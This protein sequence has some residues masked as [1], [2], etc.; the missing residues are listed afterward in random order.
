MRDAGLI[1]EELADEHDGVPASGAAGQRPAGAGRFARQLD[2]LFQT[3]HATL[4]PRPVPRLEKAYTVPDS[5]RSDVQAGILHPFPRIDAGLVI[6]LAFDSRGAAASF[7]EALEQPQWAV[8]RDADLSLDP[9]A[10]E[11]GAADQ[12]YRHL[13]FTAAGLRA[14]GLDD[15]ELELF[16]EEFR[17][18]MAQRAGLLGDVNANHPRRWHLPEAFDNAGALGVELDGVH[19][20]LQL[21]CLVAA[22]LPADADAVP[23]VLQAE[24][25]HIRQLPV[26]PRILSVQSLRRYYRREE[27]TRGS[28]ELITEHYGYADG[29]GQ[30]EIEWGTQLGEFKRNRVALGEVLLGHPNAQDRPLDA[31]CP[32][33]LQMQQ[34][35]LQWQHNGSY[36]VMRKYR[37]RVQMFNAAIEVTA[38]AMALALD[39]DTGP[40][41]ARLAHYGAIVRAKLM[42]RYPDGRSV[43]D[44]ANPRSVNAFTYDLDPTGSECPFHAHARR[45]HP[46]AR[47][48]AVVRAPRLMRRSMS[49]GPPAA[50]GET[51]DSEPPRGL[52]FMAYNTSIGE[53]FEVVQR[54]LAGGN[55]TGSSS[56]IA[57]PIVGTPVTGLP[58]HFRFE[59]EK[60]AFVVELDPCPPG[61]N[62]FDEQQVMTRLEWGLYLYSPSMTVLHRLRQRAAAVGSTPPWQIERGRAQ[63]RRLQ[64]V[65]AAGNPG[66]ALDAWKA[67][68]EDPESIDRMDSAALWAAIRADHGGLLRTPYGVLVAER[69]LVADV[70]LDRHQRYSV[71]GQ[72][73]RMRRSFGEIALGM[74]ESPEYRD[75]STAI[76]DEIGRLNK[77]AVFDSARAAVDRKIEEIRRLAFDQSQK[78]GD[79]RLEAGLDARELLDEVLA[80]LSEDWFGLQDSRGD[81]LFRRGPTDWQWQS[82]QLPLYPGHFTALSRY[83]FQPHPGP[84][85]TELGQRYGQSLRTAMRTL[86]ERHRKAG[87]TPMVPN[88]GGAATIEPAP[89]AKAVIEDPKH[90]RDATEASD[91]MARTLVGVLMGF[92]PTIIGA[93]LNVLAEWFREGLFGTMRLK[94]AHATDMATAEAVLGDAITTALKMRPM[95]QI[96]WRTA[97]ADHRLGNEPLHAVQ[98]Q[99]GDR[100]VMSIASGTQQSLADGRSDQRLMFGGVRQGPQGTYPTHACPGYSAGIGAVLGAL[101]GLLAWKNCKAL[102]PGTSAYT[103]VLEDDV[104][105]LRPTAPPQTNQPQYP[106]A[107][108]AAAPAQTRPDPRPLIMAWG[109]SWLDFP[110]APDTATIDLRDQLDASHYDV[111]ETF[112]K[113]SV[114]PKSSTLAARTDPFCTELDARLL[115]KVHPVAILLSSGGNDSTGDALRRILTSTLNEDALPYDPARLGVHI[116]GIRSNYVT[117]IDAILAVLQDHDAQVPI[118]VHGYD[119]P[120]P[121][122]KG[123]EGLLYAQK[124]MFLPFSEV[125]QLALGRKTMARLIDALNEMLIDL[126]AQRYPE[127]V[128]H[129]DLRGTLASES[130]WMDDLHPTP[131][132]FEKLAAK[133]KARIDGL[134]RSKAEAAAVTAAA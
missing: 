29:D 118:V 56:G 81:A 20:V 109:D 75:L 44:S 111:P 134:M 91:L 133:V 43:M 98:V 52:L 14:V 113:Y 61:I 67:A 86:V 22:K 50:E 66:A 106:A 11:R 58:R 105:P 7:L 127:Q 12:V 18:G 85:A 19:A 122:G 121:A 69:G 100:I 80:T 45:A 15:D 120:I 21:R 114:W 59:H 83:M 82:G 73:D 78:V 54:W 25:D 27:Q 104:P 99:A 72:F 90:A 47:P 41:R 71:S 34:Q 57:C 87:T 128:F 42:G 84:M 64:Q 38:R 132:S 33:V 129:V 116:A 115:S 76:N 103:F 93:V 124:W 39:G 96:G 31:R 55:S 13:S 97:R 32:Q 35:R 51:A 101:T 107:V 2:W 130:D 30:P 74:D 89:L 3:D 94:L 6:L 46:R 63:L 123:I 77:Q 102:R 9:A 8:T 88:R 62:A 126:A 108:P 37:Q 1:D 110:F 24:I 4:V 131:A 28:S 92:N 23:D 36:L 65:E 40:D 26:P 53:Q 17:Q 79:L 68:I 112:C 117:V 119:H 125:G 5:V 70:Y 60:Q 10:I 16:A 48:D 49:Y 95:P